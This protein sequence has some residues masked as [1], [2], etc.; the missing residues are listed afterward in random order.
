MLRSL[1]AA[2]TDVPGP[3]VI[4]LPEDVLTAECTAKAVKRQAEIT[5]MSPRKGTHFHCLFIPPNS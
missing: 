1:Q 5:S 4:A 2:T 3:V